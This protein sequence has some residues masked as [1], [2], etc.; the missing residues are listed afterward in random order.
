MV[1]TTIGLLL[2]GWCVVSFV[3]VLG[4]VVGSIFIVVADAD[5]D[6]S[7]SCEKNVASKPSVY[8]YYY[9]FLNL[10]PLYSGCKIFPLFFLLSSLLT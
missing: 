10:V 6:R 8:Y 4:S 3:L 1:A 9:F 7:T 2:G 5:K